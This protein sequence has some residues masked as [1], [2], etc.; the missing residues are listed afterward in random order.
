MFTDRKIDSKRSIT[1]FFSFF[2]FIFT[3]NYDPTFDFL[4]Q[5]AKPFGNHG[6]VVVRK[7]GDGELYRGT[8]SET[9]NFLNARMNSVSSPIKVLITPQ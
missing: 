1:S 4:D 7:G 6:F 8:N 3:K 5:N 9:S 2:P